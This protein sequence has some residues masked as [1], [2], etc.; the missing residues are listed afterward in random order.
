M[1]KEI[2][3]N[4]IQDYFCLRGLFNPQMME[5][6]KVRDLIMDCRNYINKL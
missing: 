5:H 3:L 4:R 1:D 6:D 2:L